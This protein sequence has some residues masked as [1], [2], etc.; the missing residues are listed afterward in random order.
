MGRINA[1]SRK[2]W[3]KLTD[4]VK[5]HPGMQCHWKK[6]NKFYTLC[7]AQLTVIM[8]SFNQRTIL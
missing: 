5:S 8:F 6:K 1:Q 4:E 3:Q 2:E 7:T